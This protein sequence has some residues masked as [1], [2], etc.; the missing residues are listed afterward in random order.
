MAKVTWN[1]IYKDFRRRHPNLAKQ[2]CDWRPYDY[3]KVLIILKSRSELVHDYD[4]HTANYIK[5][6]KEE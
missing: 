3:G 6:V 4:S 5:F 1:D 2:V